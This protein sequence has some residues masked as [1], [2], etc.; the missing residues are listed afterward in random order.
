MYV[1]FIVLN[2]KS[3]LEDVLSTLVKEG[4][5]GATILDSKGMAGAVIHGN[6]DS[7]PLFGSLKNFVDGA[8]PYNNTIFSVISG[9]ELLNRT[10]AAINEIFKDAKKPGAGFMFTMPV[11]GIYGLG[12]H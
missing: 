6:M 2:K 3:Y 1:L 7:M 5:R 4:V 8:Y 10:V 9:E 12:H 11:N